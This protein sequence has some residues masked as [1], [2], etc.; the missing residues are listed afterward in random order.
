MGDP[1]ANMN[2]FY[3]VRGIY[4]NAGFAFANASLGFTT[5]RDKPANYVHESKQAGI[6]AA[7]IIVAL[8]IVVPTMARLVTR[9]RSPQMQFGVDDWVIIA[10]AVSCLSL[11]FDNFCR[12][13]PIC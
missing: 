9:V 7:M 2:D 5:V 11:H 1:P 3:I 10:A 8:I 12:L 6:I 4:R 13:S